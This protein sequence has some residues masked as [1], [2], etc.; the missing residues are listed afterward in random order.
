MKRG[1]GATRA[2]KEKEKQCVQVEVQECR[3]SFGI[4]MIFLCN[5][6]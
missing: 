3:R 5:R 2:G 1:L 4:G 6:L